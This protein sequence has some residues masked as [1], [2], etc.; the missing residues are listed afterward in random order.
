MTEIVIARKNNTYKKTLIFTPI[1]LFIVFRSLV[2][3]LNSNR[4]LKWGIVIFLGILSIVGLLI[5]I[6]AIIRI[7]KKTPALIINDNGIDDNISLSK[8]GLI[9][10]EDINSYKIKKSAGTLHLFIYIKDFS[11]IIS[12][13]SGFKKQMIKTFIKDEGTPIAINLDL[14]EISQDDLVAILNENLSKLK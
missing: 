1:S 10:W 13:Q 8:T 14:I 2:N 12:R 7:R 11:H 4:D 3:N 9:N 5:F 6:N